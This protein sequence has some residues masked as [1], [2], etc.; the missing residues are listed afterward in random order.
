[1]SLFKEIFFFKPPY[2]QI[3][4][5]LHF[6][7]F[8][9]FKKLWKLHMK[10]YKTFFKCKDNKVTS[11]DLKLQNENWSYVQTHM[12]MTPFIWKKTYLVHF[13]I[14]LSDFCY[15]RCTK[16]RAKKSFWVPKATKQCT[17]IYKSLSFN[18]LGRSILLVAT[19]MQLKCLS[20]IFCHMFQVSKL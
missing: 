8:G 3:S 20:H 12:P 4:Y 7:L 16:W 11:K 2:F 19:N 17:K 5:L 10:L 6:L 1:M 13:F 14:D 18:Y 15:I 9:Q